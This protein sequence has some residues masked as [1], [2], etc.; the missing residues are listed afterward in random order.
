MIYSKRILLMISHSWWKEVRNGT[1]WSNWIKSNTFLQFIKIHFIL[2]HILLLK[3]KNVTVNHDLSLLSY[4]LKCL[5][6]RCWTLYQQ[7]HPETIFM[8]HTQLTER[9]QYLSFYD[10]VSWHLIF[11]CL[12]LLF[13]HT[14]TLPHTHPWAC[15]ARGENTLHIINRLCQTNVFQKKVE[16]K[17]VIFTYFTDSSV[18]KTNR[19][20]KSAFA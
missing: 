3:Y 9:V 4:D 10:W 14:H 5:V 17:Y 7:K 20:G 18:N 1:I 2:R 12:F 15:Y 13:M 6:P 8:S 11:S 16:Y 19:G